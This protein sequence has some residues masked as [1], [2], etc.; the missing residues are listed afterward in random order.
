MGQDLHHK[1]NTA[2]ISVTLLV[3]LALATGCQSKED[4]A[5]IDGNPPDAP[6]ATE[7]LA[8][9]PVANTQSKPAPS[10]P[11]V[12]TENLTEVD[13]RGQLAKLSPEQVRK[14]LE[15]E[16]T[17]PNLKVERQ[18]VIVPGYVPEGFEVSNLVVSESGEYDVYTY[19]DIV[20]SNPSKACF[21]VR[22]QAFD[23]PTGEGFFEAEDIEGVEVSNLGI[24]V[25]I[26]Y[27]TFWRDASSK[28][29]IVDL[30]GHDEHR[31]A[32]YAIFSPVDDVEAG[33]D[34]GPE[35]TEFVKMIQSLQYLD[36]NESRT[37]KVGNNVKPSCYPRCDN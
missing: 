37:L 11:P 35:T 10:D 24:S 34:S 4:I 17:S 21:T 36:P 20:Y 18:A 9:S 19:Y 30:S 27:A 29:M 25:D 5:T 13:Q 3:S 26:G 12:E 1:L 2:L 14:L 15:A 32:N 28:F 7:T 6:I 16:S 8:N 31:G 33:C 23:G 22:Q